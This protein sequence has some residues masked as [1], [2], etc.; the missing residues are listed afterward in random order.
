MGH[1][2]RVG[3]K[4]VERLM[5]EAGISGLIRRRRG[6]TRIRVQGVRVADDLVRRNFRPA[7]PNLLWLV[8]GLLGLVLSAQSQRP[9]KRDCRGDRA[10]GPFG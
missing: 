6:R 10:R 8:L 2:I 4:R 1:G 3:R 9:F 7:A 5:R